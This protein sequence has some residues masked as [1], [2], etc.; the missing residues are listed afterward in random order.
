[1]IRSVRIPATSLAL[2]LALSVLASCG[3][4]ADPEI[5]AIEYLRAIFSGRSDEA[6]ARVDLDALVERVSERITLVATEG[7]SNDFLR[8]SISTLL[9]GLYEATAPRDLAYNAAPAEIDGDLATVRVETADAEGT[10]ST[11]TLELR[12]TRSGWLISGRSLDPLVTYVVQ[13]LEE[14]Y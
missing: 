2:G 11:R 3:P 5:V 4:P 13:R 6:V 10:H 14:R 7:S 9:W 1:M 12:R 8:D